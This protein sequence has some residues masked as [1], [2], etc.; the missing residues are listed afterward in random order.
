MGRQLIADPEFA[1]KAARGEGDRIRECLRCCVCYPGPTGEH[2]TDPVAGHLPGLGSCTINPYN[3]NSFSHHTVLPEDMPEPRSS[4]RVLVVGGGPGGLQAAIDATDRGHRVTI[5]DDAD[6]LGGVLRLTD[7]DHYKRALKNFKDYQIREVARRD[8]ELRLETTATPELVRE[9]A[10]G[11]FVVAIGGEA[12]RPDIPGAEKAMTGFETFF[13]PAGAIGRRV[14]II[15]GGLV[16]TEVGIDLASKNHEVTVVEQR[17]RLVADNIGIHRTALLDEMDHLGIRSLVGRRCTEIL[18]DGVVVVDGDGVAELLAADTVV[19]GLGSRARGDEAKTL[20][21]AAG[22]V[23]TFV[24]GDAEHTARVG[25]AVIGGY[26]A[27]MSI[28]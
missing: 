7:H 21:D 2:E 15:G 22:D 19:I 27:A 28:V 10:P 18:D 6:R 26:R 23:P 11:A 25:E 9:F 12:I 3:V 20:V 4:R 14:V 8:I 16:G 1:N 13:A 24:I 17:E 5:V